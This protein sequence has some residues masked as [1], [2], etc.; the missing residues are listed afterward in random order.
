MDI[1]AYVNLFGALCPEAR[2]TSAKKNGKVDIMTKT[3]LLAAV[4]ESRPAYQPYYI[5]ANDVCSLHDYILLSFNKIYKKY[6]S[7]Q[8][9]KVKYLNDVID[10]S[11]Y[12]DGTAVKKTIFTNDNYTYNLATILIELVMYGLSN[13][14]RVQNENGVRTAYWMVNPKTLIDSCEKELWEQIALEAHKG[15]LLTGQHN[16]HGSVNRNPALWTTVSAIFNKT[17]IKL[18]EAK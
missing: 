9:P 1:D 5:L 4:S 3:K 14:L 16:L 6:G 15:F 2:R 7:S 13:A 12:A 8:R 11:S 10:S 18:T 17:I